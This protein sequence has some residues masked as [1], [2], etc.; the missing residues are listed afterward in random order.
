L[1]DI[2]TLRA[3]PDFPGVETDMGPVLGRPVG[4]GKVREAP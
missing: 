4:L 2:S 1:K 3:G